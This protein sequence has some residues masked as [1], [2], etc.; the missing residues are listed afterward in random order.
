MITVIGLDEYKLLMRN[1]KLTK[2]SNLEFLDNNGLS[3]LKGE[4]FKR[5]GKEAGLILYLLA[6]KGQEIKDV[7]QEVLETHTNDLIANLSL[8][9][10][11]AVMVVTKPGMTAFK[12]DRDVFEELS[13]LDLGDELERRVASTLIEPSKQEGGSCTYAISDCLYLDNVRAFLYSPTIEDKISAVKEEANRRN[14]MFSHTSM[15]T[16]K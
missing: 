16:R 8:P 14:I 6:L 2:S 3:F 15:F 7:S 11:D 13:E 12:L 5:T 4:Y 9:D 1:G 10:G